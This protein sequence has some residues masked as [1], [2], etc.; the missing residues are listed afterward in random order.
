MAHNAHRVAARRGNIDFILAIDKPGA[1]CVGVRRDRNGRQLLHRQRNGSNGR[2]VIG[3][4]A[5]DMRNDTGRHR[6]FDDQMRRMLLFSARTLW[7][8]SLRFRAKASMVRHFSVASVL[9]KYA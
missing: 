8:A 4:E 3:A 9:P 5:I 1:A 6:M 7:D 2:N